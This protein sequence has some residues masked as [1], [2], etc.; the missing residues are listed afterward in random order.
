MILIITHK[1]DYT[2]DYLIDKLNSLN[3]PYF[4]FNCE[5]F[6][7]YKIN[8]EF[9]NTKGV[10]INNLSKF[11][12]VWYRRTML[13]D[14]DCENESERIYL[15]SEMNIFLKNLF[16]VISAKWLSTPSS[17]LQAEN[18]FRQLC[19][20]KEI[21]FNVPKTLV[22]TDKKEL[23]SFIS[24]NDKTV[25]KPLGSGRINYANNSAKLIFTN[26][27]DQEVINRIDSFELTPVIYQSYIEKEIELRVTVVGCDIFAAS[28]DSQSLEETS[29]DW[30]RKKIKFEE[31]TL[32]EDLK[33][34]C[35]LMLNKLDI[36]YGAFDFIKGKDGLF[37]FL[38]INPNGQWVWVEK[39]TGML[40]SDSII[41]F[42]TC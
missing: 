20:A 26:I 27:L 12:S 36:S 39:D 13:P 29:V 42:L 28:V 7:R 24:E 4:R 18:K 6:L 31:Y 1:N 15:M 37:Y 34:K 25:I 19:I 22:T 17:V 16:E 38:E 8:L 30:R 35:L 33:Q 14:L 32:P 40:I 10:T 21:G 3:I 41:K 23:I 5:D 11:S 9:G 2:A